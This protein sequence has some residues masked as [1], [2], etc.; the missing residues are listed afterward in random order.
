MKR[1]SII[2]AVLVL[3]CI[4]WL[5]GGVGITSH[6]QTAPA[7]PSEPAPELQDVARL[8]EKHI[9]DDVIINYIKASGKTYKLSA[10]DIITLN[11]Q[12]VSQSVI[13]ALQNATPASPNPTLSQW[14]CNR[15]ARFFWPGSR[16]IPRRK[17][18]SR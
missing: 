6:A 9:G 15:T 13:A 2:R 12:G 1:N 18:R 3:A 4:G 5:G 10:D 17:S 11:S 7:T 16:S 14:R 8:S